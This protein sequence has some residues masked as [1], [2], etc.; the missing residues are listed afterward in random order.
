MTEMDLNPMLLRY[1]ICMA[2]QLVLPTRTPRCCTDTLRGLCSYAHM[3]PAL[4]LLFACAAPAQPPLAVP[5][6]GPL[7]PC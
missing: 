6:V 5:L 3:G 1:P 2:P 7:D 4:L